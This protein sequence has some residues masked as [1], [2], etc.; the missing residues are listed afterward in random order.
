MGADLAK[1]TH[2]DFAAHLDGRFFLQLDGRSV[3]LTLIEV[4]KRDGSG[5]KRSARNLNRWDSQR[6]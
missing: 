6:R 1:L 3:E 4:D 2:A 5:L